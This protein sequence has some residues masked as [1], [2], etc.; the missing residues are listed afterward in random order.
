[1]PYHNLIIIMLCAY[2]GLWESVSDVAYFIVEGHLFGLYQQGSLGN[3]M[4]LSHGYPVY[5]DKL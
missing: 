5:S 4:P 2:V 1:M 3:V